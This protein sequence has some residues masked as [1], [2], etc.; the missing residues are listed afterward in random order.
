MLPA[1]LPDQRVRQRDYLLEII[2]ALTEQLDLETVLERILRAALDLLTGRAG[3]IALHEDDGLFHVHTRAGFSAAQAV[4][5]DSLVRAFREPG[6]QD[7]LRLLLRSVAKTLGFNWREAVAL[8]LTAG[9]ESVGLIFIFRDF[10]A[11]FSRDDLALLQS[12]A[13]QAAIATHNA[14]LFR[15]VTIEKR[16]SDAILDSTADGMMIMDAAHQVQRFNRAL[17]RMTGWSASEAIGRQHDEIIRWAAR[18]SGPTLAEAEAGGWPLASEAPLYVEGDLRRRDGSPLAVGITYAPLVGR[19]GRLVNIIASVRDITKF[20]EAEALKSTFISIISHE[21]KTPV[22]LIKGYAGTLRREDARWD[23]ATVQDSL[24][25]I[26]EESDRL[27]ELIENLLDASRLQAGALRLNLLEVPL[28]AVAARLVERFRVQSPA[29][30]FRVQFPPDFPT[31]LGD[32]DR[33][34]QVLSNL[35]SNAI[36]YTPDGGT[37]TVS[38]RVESDRVVV[39]VADDGP[40]LPPEELQRVFERFYRADTPATKRAK[41]AGLGLYL[42]KAVVEAHG[43]QI[44]AESAPNRGATFLFSLPR[45]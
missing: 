8:P 16:R 18:E 11:V 2:R 28:D 13:D 26:E 3:L 7:R 29:H 45:S 40:G 42:A 39:A 15:Q 25:V 33:L 32:E 6:N 1:L 24:A 30:T 43:G 35:I 19:D 44:W 4:V 36:K 14:R 12:F 10:E 37:I 23:P 34:V 38:G 9:R 21:L 17:A 22:S 41:G 5:V 31:V 20:R 27:A